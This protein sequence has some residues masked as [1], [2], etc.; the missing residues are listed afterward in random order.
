MSADDTAVAAS[1]VKSALTVDLPR[2]TY[3]TEINKYA[4]GVTAPGNAGIWYKANG[5]DALFVNDAFDFKTATVDA[6]T[7]DT[8]KDGASALLGS[9]GAVAVAIFAT[10]F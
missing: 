2:A 5:K 8:T 4:A 1:S 6:T 7:T 9:L 3:M 10:T